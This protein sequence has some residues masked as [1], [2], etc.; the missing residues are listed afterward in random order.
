MF[1]EDPKNMT[2]LAIEAEMESLNA[3]LAKGGAVAYIDIVRSRLRLLVY[4]KKERQQREK[5]RETLTRLEEERPQREAAFEAKWN[6]MSPDE[7]YRLRRSGHAARNPNKT[8]DF[9]ALSTEEKL[10]L[11]RKASEGLYGA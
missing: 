8:A 11:M 4:A 2:D 5:R 1:T 6:A 3:T 10:R 7:Q 9:N